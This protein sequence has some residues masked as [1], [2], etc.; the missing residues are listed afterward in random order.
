MKKLASKTLK[1]ILINENNCS[2]CRTCQLWCS[3]IHTGRFSPI[4]AYI[5][6]SDEYGLSPKI[7]FLDKCNNCGQCVKYCLYDALTFKEGADQE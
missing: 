7:S 5:L 2:G 3:Y 6:I 1:I 4:D